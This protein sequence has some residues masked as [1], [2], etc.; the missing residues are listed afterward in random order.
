MRIAAPIPGIFER[1]RTSLLVCWSCH[2]DIEDLP[3]L[4]LLEA[5]ELF[6]VLLIQV[7]CLAS[8]DNGAEH[9][10]FFLEGIVKVNY[11]GH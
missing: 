6:K 4:A 7:S 3:E 1:L 2:F 11:L 5:F 9:Y 8:V 10:E